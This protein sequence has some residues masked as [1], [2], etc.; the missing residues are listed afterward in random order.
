MEDEKIDPYSQLCE[1]LISTYGEEGLSR[2]LS[3]ILGYSEVPP[4]IHEFISS[5][6]WIADSL[7]NIYPPWKEALYEIFPNPFYSPYS[8][9]IFTGAIGTGKTLIATIGFL[10]DIARVNL[11]KNAHAKFGTGPAKKIVFS[12]IN[13]TLTLA[14]DVVYDQLMDMINNSPRFR[15]FL[16]TSR[17]KRSLFK[18]NIDIV[19]GSRPTHSIGQDVIGGFLDEINFQNK[20]KSQAYDNYMSIKRRIES[21]FMT[22]NG[23][24]AR[25]WL[26]SSKTNQEGFLEEHI[27]KT[28]ENESSKVFDYAL[29]DLKKY[30]LDEQGRSPYSGKTFK[31]FIGDNNRDPRIIEKDSEL[32]DINGA[33]IINV[34][35][36]HYTSFQYNIFDALREMAGKSVGS[37]NIFITSQEL[38]KACMRLHNPIRREI[39]VLDFF[40]PTDRLIDYIDV[41]SLITP[42]YLYN[43][44]YIHLD[45]GLK[46]DKLGFASS[47]ISE[48]IPIT[49]RDNSTGKIFTVNEPFFITEIAFAIEAKK[50]SEIPINKIKSFV[51]DLSNM[52]YPLS[53]VSMDGFQCLNGNTLIITNKG[54][55]PIK[56]VEEGDI[57]YSKTGFRPVIKKLNFGIKPTLKIETTDG[58]VLEGTHNHKIEVLKKLRYKQRY[59][60]NH[61]YE[62]K[63]LDELKIGDVLRLDTTCNLDCQESQ[64]V[65][66]DKKD[67]GWHYKNT[68]SK[69]D[70]WEYPNK[71][72]P[73]LAEFIGLLYGDGSW[74]LN[75]L[76]L[77]TNYEEVNDYLHVCKNLFGNID[78]TINPKKGTKACTILINGRWITRWFKLNGFDK[79]QDPLCIPDII[80]RSSNSSKAAFLRGLFSSDGTVSKR[81]GKISLSTKSLK[82]AQDVVIL[83]SHF[84]I[85][86][87]IVLADKYATY[88][89]KRKNITH[90]CYIVS[91]R[92]SRLLFF[93][94]INFCVNT[95]REILSKYKNIKGKETFT[96]VKS[97]VESSSEVFDLNIE[98]DHSY[99]ASG[100]MSHNSDN[101]RQDLILLGIPSDNISSDRTKEPYERYKSSIIQKRWLG[102]NYT[103]L[104][105]E[106]RKLLDTPKK[107]DHPPKGSKDV[108]DAVCCSMYSAYLAYKEF[109][110]IQSVVN[111]EYGQLE[112][113]ENSTL[114]I[115]YNNE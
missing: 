84:G 36:E 3:E 24:F 29:W 78:F 46:K 85:K 17:Y 114:A 79:K 2:G 43:P 4:T 57:V 30:K 105:D 27:E 91:I 7:P 11:L 18:K 44:R 52:G 111:K 86:S 74:D 26:I 34:P 47:F 68:K 101:L 94:K 41:G 15:E 48:V 55:I 107:I 76:R 80:W 102:P 33:Y 53:K 98:E 87:K 88:D 21:R 103:L 31:V 54:H 49:V 23:Y 73:I 67:L 16:N 104:Y 42:Q 35:V 60:P 83:L 19:V 51:I 70:K 37:A 14:D 81:D 25:V 20:I 75:F 71:M 50:G 5:S 58:I 89:E 64:L 106:T 61:I 112:Y 62:W 115:G 108:S 92:G 12:I 65:N 56:E 22:L 69:A 38:I 28:K 66:I 72:N 100:I 59:I 32:Y 13:A 10:Y 109:P 99:V 82:M 97:V 39:I 1:E 110:I 113:L 96:R 6:D 40:D 95:K 63:R 9:V 77:T 90:R 8:E 45:M 93:N